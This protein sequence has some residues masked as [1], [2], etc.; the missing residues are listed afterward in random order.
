M[1]EAREPQE[2][3]DTL[4]ARA[5]LL[6]MGRALHEAGAPS[7]RI[8]DALTAL[9]LV[10]GVDGHFFTTPTSIFASFG[11]PEEQRTS[12][13]RVEPS[14][15]NLER[16]SLLDDLLREVEQGACEPA[17]AIERLR[18]I[19]TLPARHGALLTIV[20]FGV[21]SAS[22][23]RFLGGGWP[24]VAAGAAIGV[25]TGLLD[26]L[27]ARRPAAARVFEW[28]AAL[29]AALAALGWAIVIGPLAPMIAALAGLIVLV[30]G[31]SLT[32]AF[33]E[34]ATRNLVSGT[35]RLAGVAMT[36]LAIGFGL[37]LGARL[38]PLIGA[39]AL[40]HPRAPLPPWSEALALA[41][42]PF[43][44]AVLFRARPRDTWVVLVA[45][46][47]AF[48]VARTGVRLA[49]SEVGLLAAAFAVGV[50]GNVYGRLF[51]QPA[52]VPVVP[53]IVMLV[54]GVLGVQSSATL[55]GRDLL[56]GAELGFTLV[57]L[58]TALAAGLLLAN[59]IVPPR[60]AL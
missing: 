11:P 35:A 36:F 21:A 16:M 28:V 42:V 17:Q 41:V 59:L 15:V 23:A 5:F 55:L 27:A 8:E 39:A 56:S 32:L 33:T 60:R 12:L 31:L 37:A 45:C 46:V 54:P 4:A 34:L 24:E 47:V 13:I 43:A 51:G 3:G 20:C 29:A 2:T 53:A 30:P 50:T 48:L 44:L 1:N 26:R 6:A 14:G 19:S 10:L 52:A 40:A 7:H 58:A 25:Q 57:V 9:A 22:V 49:G 18:A 38:Q